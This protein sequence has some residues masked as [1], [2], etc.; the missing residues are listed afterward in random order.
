MYFTTKLHVCICRILNYRLL[1]IL[2]LYRSG[3]NGKFIRPTSAYGARPVLISRASRSAVASFSQLD[4][5]RKVRPKRIYLNRLQQLEKYGD[6]VRRTVPCTVPIRSAAKSCLLVRPRLETGQGA[7][8]L[9]SYLRLARLPQLTAHSWLAD[10]AVAWH[11][12]HRRFAPSHTRPSPKAA[13][14]YVCGEGANVES[15][16]CTS[17]LCT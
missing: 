10:S 3:N 8:R 5:D 4:A 12:S 11:L 1:Y 9:D 2:L 14:A 16:R 7:G 17:T 13:V 15:R 6:N